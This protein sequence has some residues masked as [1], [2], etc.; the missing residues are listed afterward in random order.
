MQATTTKI[1]IG[2]IDKEYPYL[3][4]VRSW[5]RWNGGTETAPER[6]ISDYLTRKLGM[7]VAPADDMPAADRLIQIFINNK[8]INSNNCPELYAGTN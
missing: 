8:V 4:Q 2:A 6:I 5:Y 1:K 7:K 3:P